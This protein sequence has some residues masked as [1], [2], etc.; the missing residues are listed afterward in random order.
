MTQ[1]LSQASYTIRR[2]TIDDIDALVQF[3]VAMQREVGKTPLSDPMAEFTRATREYMLTA[4]PEGTFIA[5]VADA[6]DGAI[7]GTSGLIFFKRPPTARDSASSDAYIINM[8][9][10]PEWRKRGIAGALVEQ[11]ITF[12]RTETSTKRIFL[13]AETEARPVYERAGFVAATDV[14]DL[15]ID[16]I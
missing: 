8:Y 13:R 5:W 2:A 3:R 7:V 10:V 14:M 11:I 1:T 15:Y 9:T 4:L 16:R 6:D 12:V